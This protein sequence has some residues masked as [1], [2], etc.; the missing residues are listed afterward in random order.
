MSL[1]PCFTC[2]KCGVSFSTRDTRPSCLKCGSEFVLPL[3][4]PLPNEQWDE[5][6]RLHAAIQEALGVQDFSRSECVSAVQALVEKDKE[7]EAHV[8]RLEEARSRSWQ[9]MHDRV[10]A[11]R[12]LLWKNRDP[13]ITPT[14]EELIHTHETKLKKLE[15]LEATPSVMAKFAQCLG[16]FD[17]SF[18]PE[19]VIGAVSLKIQVLLRDYTDLVMEVDGVLDRPDEALARVRAAVL[20]ARKLTKL[21]EVMGKL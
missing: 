15:A 20:D 13:W 8:R 4:N 16:V 12:R 21:R 19:Q 5:A 17:P 14:D 3:T 11:F 6:I 9:A 7:H 18:N 1:S 2:S 10:V